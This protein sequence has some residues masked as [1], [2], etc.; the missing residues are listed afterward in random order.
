[1]CSRIFWKVPEG[2][3]RFPQSL[4]YQKCDIKSLIGEFSPP[5]RNPE[6]IRRNPQKYQ[7]NREKSGVKSRVITA[8]AVD[9]QRTAC[10]QNLEENDLQISYP[11]TCRPCKEIP[12]GDQCLKLC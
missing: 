6:I 11:N 1:M 4:S 8:M 5:C 9:G 12:D 2:S 3:R 7:K 10:I